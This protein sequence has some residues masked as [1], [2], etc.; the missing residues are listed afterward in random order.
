MKSERRILRKQSKYYWQKF[1][2]AILI[3]IAIISFVGVFKGFQQK[4]SRKSLFGIPIVI[5]KVT[6]T[7]KPTPT[8]TPTPRPLTF[9]EMN[10]LYGPCVFLP[11]LFY[12]HIQSL[13][14]AKTNKQTALTVTTDIF[15]NQMKY[16]KDR[17]YKTATMNDLVNFF[18]NAIPIPSGSVL[19]TFDDAYADFAMD[20]VPV[21]R[22][23]GFK[24]TLF[25]PTG[26]VNNPD[27]LTWDTITSLAPG[28]DILFANHT[29]SHHNLLA[30]A[31]VIQ[32]EITT[33][34]TQLTEKGLDS[35]KVFAYPYGLASAQAE[36]VLTN[37]GYKLAFTTVPGSTLCKKLKLELPRLRI[38]DAGLSVYGF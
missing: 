12:H 24:S 2:P 9:A 8:P 30:S 15:R 23:F 7:T 35:P 25:V 37:L 6:S 16:L 11:T 26:L 5:P 17:G 13:E 33:A 18:D 34:D 4:Y 38:G 31:D 22:E 21:L 19:L 32:K 29:W 3:A 27:Y 20:A 1:L 36:A 10:A 14:A 28:G